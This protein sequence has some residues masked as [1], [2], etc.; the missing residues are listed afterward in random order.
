MPCMV[1]RV[2]FVPEDEPPVHV[3][4]REE[5]LDDAALGVRSTA[6]GCPSPEDTIAV[7][8]G[9]RRCAG[10]PQNRTLYRHTAAFR[11]GGKDRDCECRLQKAHVRLVGGR[12]REAST[13]H[14]CIV[15][16]NGKLGGHATSVGRVTPNAFHAVHV[17][18]NCQSF[19]SISKHA[20][21]SH[22]AKSAGRSFANGC[23]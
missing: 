16:C 21:H 20:H 22:I 6:I 17:L 19:V 1:R 14:T 7:A 5:A 23:C 15:D 9:R 10:W 8:H 2:S 12:C 13:A 18:H 4:P 11:P 3:Q